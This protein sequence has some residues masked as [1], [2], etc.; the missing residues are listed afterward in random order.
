MSCCPPNSTPSFRDEYSPVGTKV[1]TPQV[2][3]YAVGNPSAGGKAIIVIPDIYGWDSGRT[4]RIG[5]MLSAGVDAYVVIPK[6]FQPSFEGGTDGDALPPDFDLG[7]PRAGEC[8]PWLAQFKY[9]GV[10]KPKIEALLAHL[11]ELGVSSV[12]SVGFCW[13]GWCQAHLASEHPEIACLVTPHP[14]I[15][16]IGGLLS[17]NPL[18]LVANVWA[19]VCF[20]AFQRF[21]LKCCAGQ[22]SLAVNACR[23]RPTNLPPRW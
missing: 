11:K 10:I 21:T 16:S 7:G 19:I 18:E 1:S 4:R 12:G 3:F 23:K 9:E 22:I 13:G 5:D 20:A 17:E 14:S 8:W 6:L 15:H 2:E